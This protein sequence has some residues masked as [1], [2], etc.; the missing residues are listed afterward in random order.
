M[1][2]P[3]ISSLHLETEDL[4]APIQRRL[5][6]RLMEA[7]YS[8]R[9]AVERTVAGHEGAFADGLE[10]GVSANLCKA[11]AR[12]IEPLPTLDIDVLWARTRPVKLPPPII[13]FGP[14]EAPLLPEAARSF[15]ER[16]PRPDF[17]LFGYVRLLTRGETDDDGTIHL[18]TSIDKQPRSVKA[19]IE[20]EDYERAVQANKEGATV[21]M[22]G[23]LERIGQR[24]R[25]LSPLLHEV[26][27]DDE[28]TLED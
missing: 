14:S 1:V 4:I 21:V 3:P 24:W 27:Y 28:P 8:A 23:D 13:R 5:T 10:S 11:L 19:V 18:A 12:M 6:R 15:R 25:W 17:L 16:A 9:Q 2:P 20:R 7:L 22:W 26:I